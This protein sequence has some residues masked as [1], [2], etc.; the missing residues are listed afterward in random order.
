MHAVMCLA[1]AQRHAHC[2]R[3]KHA[4]LDTSLAQFCRAP[5]LI[6]DSSSITVW[7]WSSYQ[8]R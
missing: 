5:M 3:W 2:A 4:E 8:T 6:L 7:V 1:L